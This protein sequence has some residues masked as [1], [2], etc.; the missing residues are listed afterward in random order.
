MNYLRK[1]NESV[2]K[3]EL[4]KEFFD[5]IFD[6]LIEDGVVLDIKYDFNF[7]NKFYL[8][9]KGSEGGILVL[10]KALPTTHYIDS[11]LK[12]IDNYKEIMLDINSCIKRI[13]DE[14]PGLEHYLV[15]KKSNV[16]SDF[17]S[18]AF[19]LR[20]DMRESDVFLY[21]WYS[22]RNKTETWRR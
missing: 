9:R 22:S 18:A 3:K 10:I 6:D 16:N 13:E 15:T 14:F 11:Y 8:D 5:M 1:Y 19:S 21:F 20:D 4:D 2:D 17:D 7:F 12:E